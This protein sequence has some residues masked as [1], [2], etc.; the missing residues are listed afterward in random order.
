MKAWI[1]GHS[2]MLVVGGSLVF[3]FGL[4][5]LVLPA[6]TSRSG[7]QEHQE[8]HGPL[9][10]ADEEHEEGVVELS[11]EARQTAGVRVVPAGPGVVARFVEA[12]GIVRANQDNIASTIPTTSG[13]LSTVSVNVGDRVRRGQVLAVLRSPELARAQAELEQ[14]K[15]ELALAQQAHSRTEKLAA[16]GAFSQPPTEQAA[17]AVSE[18]A[19][20]VEEAQAEVEDRAEKVRVAARHLERAR[21]AIGLGSVGQESIEDA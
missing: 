2:K 8:E 7:A 6:L 4:A 16:A 11:Q 12:P 21:E 9:E 19:Q 10:H 15:R 14:G 5:M 3:A 20:A 1:K 13:V 17:E 18:T